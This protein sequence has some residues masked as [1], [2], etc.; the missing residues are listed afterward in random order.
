MWTNENV[1]SLVAWSVAV[2][3]A[4]LQGSQYMHK[5][6]YIYHETMRQ[7]YG[8]LTL[9]ASAF[10][11]VWPLL[12]GLDIAALFLFYNYTY[13]TCAQTYYIVA[14]AFS[15][16]TLVGYALWSFFFIRWGNAKGG[17]LCIAWSFASASVVFGMMVSS[18]VSSACPV[19]STTYP[20]GA[21]ATAFWGVQLL[22]LMMQLYTSWW[23]MYLPKYHR[24]YRMWLWQ[25][26]KQVAAQIRAAMEQ[27]Y[28]Y[29]LNKDNGYGM[30]DDS[31]SFEADE[32]V[33]SG[34]SWGDVRVNS[35]A[36]QMPLIRK[37]VIKGD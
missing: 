29:H 9:P 8:F 21:I 14:S 37:P 26:K 15:L 30:I 17:F 22:W 35:N 7:K 18:I 1:T 20:T 10:R 5:P 34:D 4:V 11:I 3:Y 27:R 36:N 2:L 6:F 24:N 16:S 31:G 32:R 19:V 13:E 28:G 33:D 23:W 25:H 12:I